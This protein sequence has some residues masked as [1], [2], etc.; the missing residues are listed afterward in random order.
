M[1]HSAQE[2]KN[3]Y[4]ASAN[5]RTK[6]AEARAVNFTFMYFDTLDSTTVC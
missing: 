2:E 5:S 3:E 1:L 6:Y 4:T